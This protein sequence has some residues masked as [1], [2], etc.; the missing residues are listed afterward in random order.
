MY[1][2]V[3]IAILLIVIFLMINSITASKTPIPMVIERIDTLKID[4]TIFKWKKGKD[5]LRDTTIYD[6]TISFVNVDTNAILKDFFA[7]NVFKDTF[8]LPEGVIWVNDTI[9]ENKI[10]GRSFNAQIT[11]KTIIKTKELR[12]PLPAPKA[13][14]YWGFMGTKQNE[15]Y[16]FGAG[17][18]YKTPEKGI[19]QFN[20]TNNSQFQLGYY[21]KIF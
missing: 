6:T 3:L 5:I 12:T 13:S 4:T 10:Y 8:S 18:M 14:L 2:N 1:K 11:Q 15:T 20:V 9:S 16:G 19:I 17:V 21:S 7:K